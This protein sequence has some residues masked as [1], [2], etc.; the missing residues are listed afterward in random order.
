MPRTGPPGC[1]KIMLATCVPWADM[2]PLPATSENPVGKEVSSAP[3]KHACVFCTGPSRTAMRMRGSPAVSAHN[4]RNPGSAA[5]LVAMSLFA[6]APRSVRF[7]FGRES[8]L[9]L[10]VDGVAPFA[11]QMFAKLHLKDGQRRS[12]R[13]DDGGNAGGH[14]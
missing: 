1:P 4:S 13:G 8:Y 7:L 14:P 12:R 6:Y 11:L 10:V 5:M 2:C 3:R 9:D